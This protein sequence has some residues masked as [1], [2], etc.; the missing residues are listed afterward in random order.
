MTVAL[1]QRTNIPVRLRHAAGDERTQRALQWIAQRHHLAAVDNTALAS[2][3][4]LEEAAKILEGSQSF[5]LTAAVGAVLLGELHPNYLIRAL[6]QRMGIEMD[7]ARAIAHDVSREIFAHVKQELVDVYHMRAQPEV[8]EPAPVGGESEP[9]E[10]AEPGGQSQEW[11]EPIQSPEPIANSAEPTEEKTAEISS[12]P[13][14]ELRPTNSLDGLAE[15]V[16][17]GAFP[18]AP[19]EPVP[20]TPEDIAQTQEPPASFTPESSGPHVVDL[21]NIDN[22]ENSFAPPPPALP[23]EGKP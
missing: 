8:H 2:A 12:T 3:S 13:G 14:S 22:I 21:R 1:P 9:L 23:E 10:S 4:S 19:Q 6:S 7:D 11:T 16:A 18:T 5:L 17:E 15:Q 20:S